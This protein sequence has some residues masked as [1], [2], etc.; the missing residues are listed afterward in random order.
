MNGKDFSAVF[1]YP[2]TQSLDVVAKIYHLATAYTETVEANGIKFVCGLQSLCIGGI[3]RGGFA[4]AEHIGN[5]ILQ[6]G[7]IFG[8]IPTESSIE[9]FAHLRLARIGFDR[10]SFYTIENALVDVESVV[11]RVFCERNDDEVA[12]FAVGSHSV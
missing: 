9:Q 8:N 7:A 12:V 2:S 4:V 6:V 1:V 5:H 3:L 11:A 10:C